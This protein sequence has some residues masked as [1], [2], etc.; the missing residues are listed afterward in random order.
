MQN[1]LFKIRSLIGIVLITVAC[2]NNNT[3]QPTPDDEAVYQ[4]CLPELDEL[5]FDIVSWNIQKYA[6]SDFQVNEVVDIILTMEADLIALQEITSVTFFEE[7]ISDLPGWEGFFSRTGDLNLAYLYK[8][9][10]VSVNGITQLFLS[11]SGP[12]PRAAALTTAMHV[13]GTK[14]SLINIHLKCCGGEDNIARRT[15]ASMMLKD[16]VDTNL[17]EDKVIIIGD[18]NDIIYSSTG[19]PITFQN[20]LDDTDNYEFADYDI[21]MTPGEWSY[22]DWPSHIDHVLITNE[23]YNQVNSIETLLIDNCQ[24]SYL[25]AVSDHRPVMMSLKK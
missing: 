5:T 13:N 23:L 2:D 8:T 1:T 3:P 19:A 10:E 16:Y 7:L 17:P 20:F 18:Y 14:A 25:T 11:E 4:Q 22:P 9:S 12:F 6:A 15:E 24:S 21:A